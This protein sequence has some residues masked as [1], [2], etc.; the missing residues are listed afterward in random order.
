VT[1]V[2]TNTITVTTK[3]LGASQLHTTSATKIERA[4][5]GGTA[6]IVVGRRVLIPSIGEVIV[7]PQGATI[8]RLVAAASN[9]SFS[10]AKVT[11]K[12]VTKIASSKMKVETIS[13]A[14]LSDI[15]TGSEVLVLVRRVSKGVFDAVEVVLIPASSALAK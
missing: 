14:N 7:L 2:G 5:A 4:V 15:K 3:R 1:A 13:S 6:D 10:I 11:G 8:G 9:G 12:G